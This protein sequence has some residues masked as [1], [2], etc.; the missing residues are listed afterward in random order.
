MNTC[1][2]SHFGKKRCIQ[3]IR[4]SFFVSFDVWCCD[5]F[6]IVDLK[7]RC[8]DL[9]PSS[10]LQPALLSGILLETLINSPCARTRV[11]SSLY[12]KKVAK[13]NLKVHTY[14][15]L[16]NVLILWRISTG[17]VNNQCFSYSIHAGTR[18]RCCCQI[19]KL[20][21]ASKVMY[22]SWIYTWRIMRCPH[23]S[24][25][26][27]IELL[28]SSWSIYIFPDL[29]IFHFLYDTSPRL[30]WGSQHFSYSIPFL[31]S[32]IIDG[33]ATSTCGFGYYLRIFISSWTP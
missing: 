25:F 27:Q 22:S 24:P 18:G 11:T 21:A 1:G 33:L 17:F 3:S 10:P 15:I 19:S 2:T 26:L 9:L 5:R 12:G 20:D 28:P 32:I 23:C 16:L 31:A 4:R 8:S 13:L 6:R 7:P 30:L 29:V 14:N